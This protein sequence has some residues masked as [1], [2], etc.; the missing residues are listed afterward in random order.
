MT[1]LDDKEVFISELHNEVLMHCNHDQ[2]K[3]IFIQHI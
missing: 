2:E 3:Q 1:I